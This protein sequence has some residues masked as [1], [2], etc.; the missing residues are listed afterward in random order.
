MISSEGADDATT[1]ARDTL[2][3]DVGG[4]LL[5]VNAAELAPI[6]ARHGGVAT[7]EGFLRAH[8]AAHNEAYPTHGEPGDYYALLPRHAG[9]PRPRWAACTAEYLAASRARNMWHHPDPASRATLARLQRA[10]TKIAVVSSA[11]GRIAQMLR[12]AAMCQVGEG[13]GVPIDAV[14]DSTVVGLDKPD[15]RF[16]RA[17]LD[18]V[19]SSPERAV[20][21]GDTVPADV[22]GARAAGILAI[23]LDPYGDC[24]APDDHHHVHTLTEIEPLLSP[25]TSAA[26]SGT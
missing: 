1:G 3:V 13:P 26:L 2:L 11:D 7:P 19:G 24:D 4:V 25:A 20:H 15:P 9:V 5:L 14:L 8:Y 18:A 12:D 23:H 10:G 17:A 22:V 21:V 16:F 6:T